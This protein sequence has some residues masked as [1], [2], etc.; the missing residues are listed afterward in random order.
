MSTTAKK[1]T[2]TTKTAPKKQATS[3][4][5]KKAFLRSAG[6]AFGEARTATK[7]STR[8]KP[9][10]KAV[11]TKAKAAAAKVTDPRRAD[12]VRL[13]EGRTSRAIEQIR[14]L[15]NL[16]NLSAYD[17]SQADVDQILE[18]LET[19]I[20]ATRSRFATALERATLKRERS[21]FK[22]GGF[23]STAARA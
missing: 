7:S 15:G 11:P 23:D 21:Q 17:Y 20:A 10:A 6:L 2:K 12:F 4:G 3:R 16:S 13:A 19:E 1:T 8:A 18:T 22:L 5:V 14:L 9:A